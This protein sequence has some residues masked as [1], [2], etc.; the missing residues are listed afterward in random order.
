M[1]SQKE[2]TVVL[3]G[4][5]TVGDVLKFK[6]EERRGVRVTPPRKIWYGSSPER[7]QLC[8]CSLLEEKIFYDAKSLV[9]PWAIMCLNCFND[10]GLG[11]GTGLGQVYERE[12]ESGEW[13]KVAG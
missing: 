8:G 13:V 12:K 2:S 1:S 10:K 4:E 6:E 9:G 5:P 3:T 7:C 11:V